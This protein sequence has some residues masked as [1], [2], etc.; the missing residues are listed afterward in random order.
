MNDGYARTLDSRW[1]RERLRQAFYRALLGCSFW[2]DPTPY[3]MTISDKPAFVWYRVAKC[4][5]RTIF[6]QLAKH[7]V[8]FVS[9]KHISFRY[10]PLRYRAHFKFAFVRNPWDRLVSCWQN[11]VV[12]NPNARMFGDRLG[13]LQ[14]FPAFVDFLAEQ[15][16]EA[17][18]KHFRLQCRLI[19][20]N[21]VDFVGRLERFDDDFRQVCDRLS[22]PGDPRKVNVSARQRD[23]RPYYTDAA[24]EKAASLYRRDITLF[25]YSFDP[26]GKTAPAATE[27]AIP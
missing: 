3:Y 7:Q 25:G 18:N 23:Y 24:A 22:L 8:A 12:D 9:P 11:K 17:G 21:H 26:P 20:L 1:S 5:T 16:L 27:T 19:D 6:A 15:D 2:P 4:A 13:K 14:S 10:A